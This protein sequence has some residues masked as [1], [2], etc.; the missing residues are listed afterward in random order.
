MSKSKLNVKS[1]YK[2]NKVKRVLR[3]KD[4]DFEPATY[5][6]Y[7]VSGPNKFKKYFCS[8]A[9]AYAFITNYT[10]TKMSVSE[11]TNLISEIKRMK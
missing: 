1:R 9:D 5:E 4:N 7:K 6:V 3:M 11:V 2:V 8:R 10:N